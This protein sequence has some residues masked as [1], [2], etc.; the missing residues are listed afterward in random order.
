MRRFFV[1]LQKRVE[2]WKLIES[3][4]NRQGRDSIF[5]LGT[6]WPPDV[7]SSLEEDLA[8]AESSA[9]LPR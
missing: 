4:A 1:N 3:Y 9:Q 8:T 7:I 2:L 5:A 6:L